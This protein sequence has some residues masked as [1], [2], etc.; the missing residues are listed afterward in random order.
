M[1]KISQLEEE[2]NQ[3]KAQLAQCEEENRK[4]KEEKDRVTQY[5]FALK[6]KSNDIN[7]I[8]VDDYKEVSVIGSGATSIVKVVTKEEKFAKKELKDISYDKSR[9]FIRESEV[10]SKFP[11]PCIVDII[12][13][14]NG[15]DKHAPCLI[16]SC[17]AK[18]LEFAITNNELDN[19]QKCMIIVEIVL[20]M[21]YIHLRNFMHRDLKPSNILLS[22]DNHVRISDFGLAREENLGTL[23]SMGVGTLRFMA[24][25]LL[26]EETDDK[27]QKVSKYS[28]KVDVY[29]FGI[30]LIYILTGNYPN[31]NMRNVVT[32]VPPSL[33]DTIVEWVRELIVR[34]LSL[35]PENRPA[36]SEIFDIIKSNNYNFFN[37]SKD[38]NLTKQQLILKQNIEARVLKIEAFEYLHQED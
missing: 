2:L 10:L 4:L 22:E 30:S 21:R 17:E 29:S 26:V 3:T 38:K 31:F 37:D 33:P 25:E 12:G 6:T 14:S 18:S 20:G 28:K 13:A 27:G 5:L 16:L 35:L 11:H 19:G 32:G 36:F 23:M 15:D 8:N 34:C 9:A 1:T 7:F 24:P